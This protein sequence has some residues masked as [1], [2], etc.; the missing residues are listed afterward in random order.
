MSPPLLAAYW[1]S[2]CSPLNLG[3]Y[4]T[5]VLIGLFGYEFLAYED[6]ARD[7]RL[8]EFETCLFAVG[9]IL[10]SDWCR[11]VKKKKSVWGS[12]D[13]GDSRWKEEHLRDCV[14]HGVRGPLTVQRLG[15]PHTTPTGDP[16]LLLPLLVPLSPQSDAGVIYIPHFNSRAALPASTLAS[17]GASRLIDIG[18]TR[19]DFLSRLQ[20]IVD[21]EFVLTGSLHG[22]II[23]QAYGRPWA[24]CIP[25]GAR[26]DK[27]GKWHDWF[28]YLG[29]DPA[30]C[31][32]HSEGRRWWQEKGRTGTIKDLRPMMRAL[33]M[34]ILNPATRAT[35][36][37]ACQP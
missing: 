34:P 16:A 19:G 18:I 4:L 3:D 9:S 22:A 5:E 28:A 12:G 23:A 10:D 30:F 24:L 32:T 7:Q 14:I 35:W 17:T 13:W 15:L 33:P 36:E 31:R 29:L 27:P 11:R 20:A 6:A 8:A 37:V 21:A 2:G 25:P 1:R 26:H